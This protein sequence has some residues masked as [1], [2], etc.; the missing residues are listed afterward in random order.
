MSGETI[1]FAGRW[2][3]RREQSR[4]R[5]LQRERI[6]SFVADLSR[7]FDGPDTADDLVDLSEDW[8]AEFSAATFV[9]LLYAAVEDGMIRSLTLDFAWTEPEDESTEEDVRAVLTLAA[10]LGARHE[11]VVWFLED[12]VPLDEPTE[13]SRVARDLAAP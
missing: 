9:L 5:P 12:D 13:V 6:R 2:E 10:E 1:V 4:W 8:Q 11:A 7:R 3:E